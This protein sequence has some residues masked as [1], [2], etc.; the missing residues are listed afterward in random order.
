MPVLDKNKKAQLSLTN[1]HDAVEIRVMGHSRASKVTPFGSLHMFSY[2]CPIVT[3]CL[4]CTVFQIW[5]HIGQKSHKNLSHSSF[6]TFLGGGPL[7]IFY[8]LSESKTRAIRWCTFHD[9]AFA[10]LDTIPAVTD[11]Q[12]D[13]L[14]THSV[15]WAKI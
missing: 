2:Y 12:T 3:F 13:T 9:P 7:R 4:K 5:Q 14:L 11:G 10:L 15:A 8:T 6:G 1:P